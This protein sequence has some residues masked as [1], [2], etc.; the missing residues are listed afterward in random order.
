MGSMKFS[1][2]NRFSM[3]SWTQILLTLFFITG[4]LNVAAQTYE[5]AKGS[6]ERKAVLDALRIPVERDLK[7]KIVFVA[8]HFRVQGEWAFVSG[9]PTTTTGADPNLAGTAWEGQE[10]LFDDNFFGL[11]RKRSGKWRVVAHAL[12]CTDVCYLDWSSRYRAPKAIFPF[13]E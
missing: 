12:G 10:D 8:D 6:A 11:L 5:P 3:N 2:V 9:R 1:S 4:A 13:T 7:Q